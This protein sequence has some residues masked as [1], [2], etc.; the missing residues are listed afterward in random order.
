VA[1]IAN[2][3]TFCSKVKNGEDVLEEKTDEEEQTSDDN[4]Y[5]LPDGRVI[6]ITEK[7]RNTVAEILFEPQVSCSKLV[8]VNI[9]LSSPCCFLAGSWR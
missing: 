2:F 7:E 5:E 4:T 8:H 9:A 3:S 1:T 6:S